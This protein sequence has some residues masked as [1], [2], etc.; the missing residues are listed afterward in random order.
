MKESAAVGGWESQP[1]LPVQTRR[2]GCLGP[3]SPPSCSLIPAL[4]LHKFIFKNLDASFSESDLKI[5]ACEP[6]VTMCI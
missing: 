3:S 5:Y 2:Q 6:V 1:W 4:A